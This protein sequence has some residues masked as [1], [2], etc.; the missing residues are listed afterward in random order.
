[1]CGE[2]RS[3]IRPQGE[4]K[5][6]EGKVKSQAARFRIFDTKK[7]IRKVRPLGEVTDQ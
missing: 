3:A 4:F 7:E 6:T 1:M 5:D 2:R